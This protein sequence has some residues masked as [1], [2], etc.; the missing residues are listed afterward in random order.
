VTIC[1]NNLTLWLTRITDSFIDRVRLLKK[2]L[3]EI[4]WVGI[5]VFIRVI[6]TVLLEQSMG[7]DWL[8]VV[9]IRLRPRA[10]TSMMSHVIAPDST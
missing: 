3:S 9:V 7:V 1:T 8:V 10:Y 6:E 5:D 2:F 4:V